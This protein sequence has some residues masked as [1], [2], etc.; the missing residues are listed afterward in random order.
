MTLEAARNRYPGFMPR[1][2]AQR[3]ARATRALAAI[4]EA[5]ERVARTNDNLTRAD[6][7]AVLLDEARGALRE[8]RL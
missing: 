5:E 2:D 8:A 3:L 7:L 6:A 4:V 1:E